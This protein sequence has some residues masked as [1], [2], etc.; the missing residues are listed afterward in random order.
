MPSF[1]V[2]G[3]ARYLAASYVANSSSS[4]DYKPE[5]DNI[6]IYHVQ[7]KWRRIARR[8]VWKRMLNIIGKAGVTVKLVNPR[9]GETITI[10]NTL[11]T[12]KIPQE[13][14]DEVKVK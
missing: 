5:D 13:W 2:R 12:P 8:K 4:P 1:L 9:T 7:R 6:R 10:G 14:L 3:V 11:P